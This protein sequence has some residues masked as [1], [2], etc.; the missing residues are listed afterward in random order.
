MTE[1]REIPRLCAWCT[2]PTLAAARA[3]CQAEKCPF[4]GPPPKEAA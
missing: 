1:P 4:R 2:N 3:A